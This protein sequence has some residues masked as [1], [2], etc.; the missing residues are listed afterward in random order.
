M[1]LYND[2]D[3]F[4]KIIWGA[5]DTETFTYIDGEKV[6]EERLKALGR[7]HPQSFFR[8]HA[9]VR[10]WAWQFSDGAHFFVTNEFDEYINFL[11]EHKVKS[12]W[13]YNA[14]FD[15]A[16]I[17]YQL[18]THNPAYRPLLNDDKKSTPF[19]FS[20]LHSDK[21]GRYSLKVWT[22]YK[23]HG[24]GSR[25]SNRSVHTC[26]TTFYDFCNIFGGGLKRLL[27]E[28]NVVDFNGQKI[29]KTSMNYQNVDEFALTEKDF[30]YLK[31]DTCGLY[32][33]IRIASET[34]EHLTG[35][36]LTKAKPDVMT[37][38]GLAKKVLLRYL[39][40][41]IPEF[42]R[43]KAFQREHP[44]TIEQDKFFR[45]K[46]LYNGGVCMLNP[47]FQNRL[48]TEN[49]MKARFG[50][51]MRRYDVNSEYP[52]IMSTMPDIYG[53]ASVMT[54]SQW[55]KATKVFKE[56]RVAIY[57][58]N[59]LNMRI[60]AGYVASFRN[61]YNGEFEK[62]VNIDNRYL[63]FENEVNELEHWYDI[64]N[65]V[66]KVI[67]YPTRKNEGYSRFVNDFYTLKKE[68]K[69]AGEKA[70]T[71]F[72]KLL[73]NSSYGKLAERV[74]RAIT[75]RDISPETG[76]VRLVNNGDIEV[77]E[78]SMLSIVQGAYITATARVWVLSHIREICNEHVT[79]R[80]VYCDTDSIHAFVTY[81]KA[82]AYN[83]GGFKDESPEQGFN[84]IKYIAPK[85]YF[86]AKIDPATG[87]TE[88]IEIH[89]KGLNVKL[90]ADEFT[91]GVIN[92]A[93][94]W[95]N[96]ND[97]D[98]RFA[99]GQKFQP[100]SGMN[101]RGGKALIPIEK[102]LAKPVKGFADCVGGLME[103]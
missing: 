42:K 75:Y 24:K 103:Y 7:E 64:D 38:G 71:A 78:T 77:D 72:A 58:F 49:E 55:Q 30:E 48:I 34:L 50:Q 94:L 91:D 40:P 89:S 37:A 28:F 83:L 96:I 36:T 16:Q 10:V 68:S 65:T 5:S 54:F 11:C 43:K 1:T 14:K 81:D 84:A 67:V 86:D 80:F 61:G 93:P 101:I 2:F 17:D 29:R 70:K 27:E 66:E 32:H 8:E 3:P 82:D 13:F 20:S 21:G 52:F 87:S 41:D 90:I 99:T 97:I 57:M 33:L 69:K 6:S 4:E 39:Y 62:N 79:E 25:K 12:V 59:T 18:L 102:Y 74:V 46:R 26:S 45:E 63:I 51:N 44:I 15:F 92:G 53:K 73:L 95:K 9:S 23:A 22:P 100:L 35:Y 56:T 85:C 31:N 60:K 98:K 19:T 76:A 88:D 47:A